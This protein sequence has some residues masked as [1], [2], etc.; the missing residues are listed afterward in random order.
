[1]FGTKKLRE[2]YEAK[3]AELVGQN[4]ALQSRLAELENQRF[5]CEQELQED[6]RRRAFYS[7]LFENLDSFE[8]TLTGS[9]ETLLTMSESLMAGKHQADEVS[10]VSE[11]AESNSQQLQETLQRVVE[12]I[13]EAAEHV[14]QLEVRVEA[15]TQIL[16]FINQIADQT[17]LLALNAA[18]EAARAGEHGRGF[19]VVA[20]E[21]RS[22]STRTGEATEE[23]ARE[24]SAIQAETLATRD[25]MSQ[26][27]EAYELLASASEQSSRGMKGVFGTLHAMGSLIASSAHRSFVELAKTDHLIFKFRIYRSLMAK[28]ERPEAPL[29]LSDHHQCRLGRWYYEGEGRQCFSR[30]PEFRAIEQPHREV[31]ERGVAALASFQDGKREQVL[32]D[33]K[34]MEEASIKVQENL[35]SL[36]SY[37]ENQD[38]IRCESEVP[39]PE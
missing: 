16:G 10:H 39:A 25:R 3:I 15:I 29:T 22:L 31:H 37:V 9:Q 6:E 20:E 13:A 11:Q 18:I 2:S 30:L 21:V 19:A 28:P 33:L 17:N 12:A 8:R 34:A 26:L 38:E 5:T 32:A 23:I 27:S 35:E 7:G 14:G 1:M 4:A 24:I 36:A